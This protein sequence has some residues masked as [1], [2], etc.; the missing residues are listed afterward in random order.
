LRIMHAILSRGFA[1]SERS[2]AESCNEQT[3]RH[4]VLL[5]VWRGH[6]DR[7]GRSVV[8]RLDPR[9]GVMEIPRRLFARRALRTCIESFRPSVIHAHLRRSVDLIASLRPDAALAA[10]L[11]V[12][13]N[14]DR[15]FQMDGL[16][17]NARWQVAAVA[18]RFKGRILKA[19]NS[20]EPH[21][22]IEAARRMAIRRDLGVG[23]GEFLVGGAGRYTAEKGWDQL[24]AAVRRLPDLP[25]LRLRLFGA[26]RLQRRLTALAAGDARISVGGFRHDIKDLYQA[27]DL[28]VCP[29]RFEPLPRVLLEAMDAQ[30]PVIASSADG[31][32]ELLDDYGGTRFELEDVDGLASAIRRHHDGLVPFAPADLR[33]HHVE[34]ANAEVQAF[35]ES[36]LEA[37]TGAA[38]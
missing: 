18:P 31:C 33:R 27:M 28:F 2:T 24:V 34:A 14:S 37:R 22:R 20:V 4:E 35:Y 29:S 15:Y 8:D 32:A 13:P 1:G 9:V 19:H 10:T 30:V 5:V 16:I 6:R 3:K 12:E 7:A 11:H 25:T 36:L 26:G 38:R 21:P 23:E 17:C